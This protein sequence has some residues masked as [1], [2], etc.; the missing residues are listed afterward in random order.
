MDDM[1]NPKN[2]L[3][4]QMFVESLKSF[5]KKMRKGKGIPQHEALDEVAKL[6]GFHNWSMLHKFAV[7]ADDEKLGKIIL[8]VLTHSLLSDALGGHFLATDGMKIVRDS[9]VEE[10]IEAGRTKYTPLV[11]F[12][13]YDSESESGYAW[14]SVEMA[15]ELADMFSDRF[16]HEWIESAAQ[17]LE[18]DGPW[19]LEDYGRD[20]D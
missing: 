2:Q 8:A 17:H 18:E 4:A 12:A 13:F 19:G 15:E 11:D 9:A 3:D 10:M 6:L 5:A 14:P 20:D 7:A 1:H 16:P